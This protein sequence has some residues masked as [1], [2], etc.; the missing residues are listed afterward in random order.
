MKRHGERNAVAGRA[1]LI[2]GAAGGIGGAAT[3]ALAASGYTVFAG[4]LNEQEADQL[5]DLEL[6]CVMPILLDVSQGE[7]ITAALNA[8]TSKLAPGM[9]LVGL[10][11]SAGL[12]YNA[13][14]E[15]L[16]PEEIRRMVDV[17]L[18]GSILL[19]RASLPL[20]RRNRSHVIFIGSA[21][22]LVASPI[23]STYAATKFGIEGLADSLRLE[24]KPLGIQVSLVEPGV[25]RTPMTAAAP[26]LLEVML[27]RMK[28]EDRDRYQGVMQ[29]I[30]AV[31][32]G[33]KSGI[34][35]EK[36]ARTICHVLEASRSRAR[37]Q[38]G[39]DSKIAAYLR[40]CPESFRDFIQGK[41]FGI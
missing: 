24:F 11:N 32:S 34:P 6:K 4:V 30:A 41:A 2:S 13:P 12:N 35:P 18:T 36:V 28:K 21:T 22:G 33:P 23:V 25:V 26:R 10:I 38:V 15:Y 31:S 39:I 16:S 3:R 1:V 7:S 17:N 9:N 14:L 29:K 8:V 20:L 19:T 27:G 5:A 40:H 37:Y